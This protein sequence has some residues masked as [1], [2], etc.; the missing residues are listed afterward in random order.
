LRVFQFLGSTLGSDR[1][2]VAGERSER[3]GPFMQRTYGRPQRGLDE[4]VATFEQLASAYNM[5]EVA[6]KPRCGGGADRP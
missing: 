1:A 4:L 2:R 6:A 3:C 5:A